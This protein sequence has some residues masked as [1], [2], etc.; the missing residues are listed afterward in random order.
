MIPNL[1]VDK[2]T[3]LLALRLV[4][5]SKEQFCKRKWSD[6]GGDPPAVLPVLWRH[7]DQLTVLRNNNIFGNIL[8]LR[9]IF[10][11]TRLDYWRR[12]STEDC[13]GSEWKQGQGGAGER[14]QCWR[15]LYGRD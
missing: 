13:G 6:I 11:G 4:E 14:N 12:L 15:Q 7:L 5:T 1:G 9:N 8:F 3:N 2:V 10:F